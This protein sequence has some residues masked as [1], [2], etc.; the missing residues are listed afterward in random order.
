MGFVLGLGGVLLIAHAYLYWRL[1][2]CTGTTRR[3]RVT[4]AAVL[5]ALCATVLVSLVAQQWAIG[6]R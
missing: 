1:V 6:R 5:A 3:W 2:H 4:G